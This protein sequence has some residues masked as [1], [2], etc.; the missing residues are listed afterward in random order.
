MDTKTRLH[1][2]RLHS[3]FCFVVVA[4]VVVVAAAAPA[5]A[6]MFFSSSSYHSLTKWQLSLEHSDLLTLFFRFVAFCK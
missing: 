1:F 4:T 5:A 2:G 6:V 3:L